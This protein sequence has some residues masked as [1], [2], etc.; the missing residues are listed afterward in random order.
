MNIVRI[1]LGDIHVFVC[2]I[3]GE[4]MKNTVMIYSLRISC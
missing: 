3:N 2:V 1:S 4:K